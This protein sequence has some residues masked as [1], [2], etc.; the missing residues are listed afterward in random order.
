MCRNS[1]MLTNVIS[2]WH[3]EYLLKEEIKFLSKQRVCT[4]DAMTQSGPM[5][6]VWNKSGRQFGTMLLVTHLRPAHSQATRGFHGMQHGATQK[7]REN[8]LQI[9]QCSRTK[10]VEEVP[11]SE[12]HTGSINKLIRGI[13]LAGTPCK[14]D[15]SEQHS[16]VDQRVTSCVT[17]NAP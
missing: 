6:T 17:S 3:A 10:R 12:N 14:S 13:W 4:Q 15:G 7:S 8:F 5:H 16:T 2:E 11:S 9:R 1:W